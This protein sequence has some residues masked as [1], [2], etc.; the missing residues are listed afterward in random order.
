MMAILLAF[1]FISDGLGRVMVRTPFLKVAL[2]LSGSAANGRVI[3]RAKP[4]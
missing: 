2:A 3:E 1:A 4:P